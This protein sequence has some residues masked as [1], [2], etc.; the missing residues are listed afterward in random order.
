MDFGTI[1][2]YGP[3]LEG[4]LEIQIVSGHPTLTCAGLPGNSYSIERAPSLI[5][6]ISWLTL[7]STN[8]PANGRFEFSDQN[9][10]AAGAFYRLTR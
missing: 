9:S 7:L 1:F 5:S 6:P 10:P 4:I 8:A 3:P 2:R